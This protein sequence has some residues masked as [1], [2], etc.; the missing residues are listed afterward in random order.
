[1]I[2][3]QD[4]RYRFAHDKLREE[5]LALLTV[6]QQRHIHRDLAKA[7]ETIRPRYA[8]V[9]GGDQN[10]YC[11]PTELVCVQCLSHSECPA[12]DG[13]ASWRNVSGPGSG[14]ESTSL[15]FSTLLSTPTAFGTTDVLAGAN[16]STTGN[17]SISV[18]DL[19]TGELPYVFGTSH[20]ASTPVWAPDGNT[21]YFN[22]DRSG[23]W[24]IW[25]M[26]ADGAGPDDA[27][28]EILCEQGLVLVG[29]AA[30]HAATKVMVDGTVVGR[31][32][33]SWRNL[34]KDAYLAEM[35]HF[36]RCVERGK[37][38]AATGQDGLRAVE[39]VMA[40]NASLCT[41][42]PVEIGKDDLP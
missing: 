35:E 42:R 30:V 6:E 40:T 27:R 5:V 15:N 13:G 33:R 17:E 16:G 19:R 31:A 38:P 8:V 9:S 26:P 29:H 2:E 36:I 12:L 20:D 39:M 22:S 21:I 4:N 1:M 10:K 24:D 3:V 41:G 32:V 28:A 34:F 18:V 7:L 14:L 25:R 11:H 23:S 37:E